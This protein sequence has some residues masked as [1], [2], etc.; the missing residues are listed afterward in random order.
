[1]SKYMQKAWADFA[2]DPATG[3]GWGGV[4]D[5]GVLGGWSED[6]V[7]TVVTVGEEVVDPRCAFFDELYAAAI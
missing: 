4:T 1:M 5:I 3:P 7:E 2:K 6:G